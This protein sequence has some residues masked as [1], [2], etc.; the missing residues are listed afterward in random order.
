MGSLLAN[1]QSAVKRLC[2]SEADA[3]KILTN[4]DQ[5]FTLD[6]NHGI[7]LVFEG[8]RIFDRHSDYHSPLGCKNLNFSKTISK[9]WIWRKTSYTPRTE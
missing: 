8:W 9:I 5:A 6:S 7:Q 3:S 1:P 4:R 2:D